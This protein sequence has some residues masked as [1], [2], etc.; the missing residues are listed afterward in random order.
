MEGGGTDWFGGGRRW[1]GR[2]FLVE[3]GR[4][5]EVKVV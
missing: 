4:D 5:R 1:W 3:R 2:T